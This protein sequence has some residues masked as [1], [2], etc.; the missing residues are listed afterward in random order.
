MRPTPDTRTDLAVTAL[1][2]QL[3]HPLAREFAELRQI[4]LGVAPEIHEGIKWNA[5][6]FRT[7]DWFATVHLRST[8]K[9][10]LIFHL[11]AKVKSLPPGGLHLADPAGLIRW[12]AK[13][14][15]LVTLGTGKDLATHRAAFE[16][17]VRAWIN[18]L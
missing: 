15:C 11:G 14:R 5:P 12:L 18:Y 9:A 3:D 16:A 7:T 13:D 6:S 10:Q 17:V 8:D 2:A 1:L 4:V